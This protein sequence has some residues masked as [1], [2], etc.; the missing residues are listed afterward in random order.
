M[1][2]VCSLFIKEREVRTHVKERKKLKTEKINQK[3]EEGGKGKNVWWI[4]VYYHHKKM[5]PQPVAPEEYMR[6]NPFPSSLSVETEGSEARSS[7]VSFLFCKQGWAQSF[8]PR[9]ILRGR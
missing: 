5:S 9:T 8:R 6:F 4:S 7:G 3:A 2:S 1:F